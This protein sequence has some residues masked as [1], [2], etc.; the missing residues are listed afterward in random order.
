MANRTQLK[1]VKKNRTKH[2]RNRC[3]NKLSVTRRREIKLELMKKDKA[4]DEGFQ[5]QQN[6]QSDKSYLE[7]EI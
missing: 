1:G 3:K 6:E 4:L 5:T 2:K 7:I